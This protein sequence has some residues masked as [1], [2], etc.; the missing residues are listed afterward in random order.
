[1]KLATYIFRKKSPF[2]KRF[3]TALFSTQRL[4]DRIWNLYYGDVFHEQ[5]QRY[6]KQPVTLMPLTIDALAGLF[7]LLFVGS[8]SALATFFAELLKKNCFFKQ[9]QKKEIK[10][11]AFPK[12]KVL[13]VSFGQSEV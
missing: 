12:R 9:K 2:I 5:R 4:T 3:N 13:S 7:L 1:L 8:A 6:C 11:F 10:N